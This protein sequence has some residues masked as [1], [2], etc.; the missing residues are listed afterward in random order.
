MK[1]LLEH[2]GL[3]SHEVL[4]ALLPLALEDDVPQVVLV[5]GYVKG[6]DG[7]KLSEHLQAFVARGGAVVGLGGAGAPEGQSGTGVL[8]GLFE[9]FG[10][11]PVL[12]ES[13]VEPGF[14]QSRWQTLGEGWIKSRERRH[15]VLAGF[16]DVPLHVFGGQAVRSAGGKAGAKALAGIVG[17]DGKSRPLVT[18]SEKRAAKGTGLAFFVAVDVP[19]SAAYIRTGRPVHFDAISSSDGTAPLCDGKLKAED[20]MVLD[21]LRDRHPVDERGRLARTAG[22]KAWPIF[23]QPIADALAQLLLRAIAYAATRTGVRLPRL[24]YHPDG[25]EAVGHVSHDSDGN[26]PALGER[27]HEVMRQAEV[28]STWC[29]L[30][31]GYDAAFYEKLKAYGHEIALH[32]DATGVPR[33]PFRRWGEPNLDFQLRWLQE[34]ADL[35]GAEGVV[36]NKNHYTRWE[37]S[38]EFL[39]WCAARGIRVEQSR[40]PSKRGTLGYPFGSCHAHYLYDA[41]GRRIDTLVLAFQTQDLVVTAPA[42]WGRLFV[43]RARRWHGVCHLLY[44]PAHIDKPGVAE[45]LLDA[46]AYGRKRGLRWLT[47]REIGAYERARR[48]CLAERANRAGAGLRLNA[49]QVLEGATLHVLGSTPFH[50]KSVGSRKVW[51]EGFDWQEAVLPR[52]QGE[53]VLE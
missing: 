3:F 51:R 49:P 39:E 11:Q 40:G 47:S 26:D 36:S 8:D 7:R 25:L 43:D 12:N 42:T 35:R 45:S 31:P 19:G 41:L 46:A 37:G 48:A 20:G 10:L 34:A 50:A 6:D 23:D 38:L 16:D 22:A 21:F 13:F 52:A 24:W 28:R 15:P 9:L 44:H 29:T 2:A 27:L 14:G 4:P 17:L 5:A 53:L 1:E 30:H 18:L 32:Y 33:E